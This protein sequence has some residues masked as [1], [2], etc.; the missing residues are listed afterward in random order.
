MAF[1]PADEMQHVIKRN[2]HELNTR[3][4]V[5]NANGIAPARIQVP[6][7]EERAPMAEPSEFDI[8]LGA[9]QN[10]DMRTEMKTGYSFN[11][12]E[13]KE[14][15][16][17]QAR[18][19]AQQDVHDRIVAG[20]ARIAPQRDPAYAG[21]APAAA[22]E[23]HMQV[24]DQSNQPPGAGSEGIYTQDNAGSDDLAAAFAATTAGEEMNSAKVQEL[25]RSAGQ[26]K[27]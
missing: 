24:N 21:S 27:S 7:M 18:R 8:Q 10:S 20:D 4:G 12:L 25:I 15:R 19:V 6:V 17:A 26:G 1:A 5:V 22:A 3:A 11:R 23:V 13:A 14:Q 2:V 16:D 9:R